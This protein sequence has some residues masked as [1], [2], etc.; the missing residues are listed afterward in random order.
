VAEGA[1]VV[2]ADLNADKGRELARQLGAPANFVALD[3][4]AE[5]SWVAAIEDVRR[6]HGRLDVLVNSAGI[7]VP[8]DIETAEFAHWRHT[9]KVNADSVFLGCKYGLALL[10]ETTRSGAIVNLASTLGLRPQPGFVAYDSSK[11]SV[12]AVTRAVALHCCQKGYPIRVNSV[13]PGATLTPMM[14]GYLDAAPDR[15]AMLSMFAANHP[16]NR[17]GTPEE[18]ANA[19]LFLASDEASFITGVALPVDGGYCAL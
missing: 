18:L 16:M 11:A 8:A 5:D 6:V 7:S 19:V 14:Q 3:A 4:T 15:D 2:I 13:H 1:R 9:H 17:V 12:W 10:K